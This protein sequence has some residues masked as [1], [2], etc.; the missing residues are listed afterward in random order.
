MTSLPLWPLWSNIWRK[1]L[2]KRFMQQNKIDPLHKNV[3]AALCFE[4]SN[5]Y[6]YDPRS[7]FRESIPIRKPMG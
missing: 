1:R 7:F 6:N 4:D 2:Q 5:T 3:K